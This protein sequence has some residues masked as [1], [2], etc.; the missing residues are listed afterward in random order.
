QW[1]TEAN[2]R[3]DVGFAED[4]RR[5]V[6]RESRLIRIGL[7]A[8][9][10]VTIGFGG[11]FIA[12]A[13]TLASPADVMLAAEVWFFILVTWAGCLWIARGTWRPL[14]ETTAAFID[15][16]IR[17]CRSNLR[18]ASF[19]AWLYVCQLLFVVLWKFYSSSIELTVL[20]TAW[21]V[22]LLGWLGL[23]AFFAL[24]FWFVRRQR[25]ELDRLLELEH[26]LTARPVDDA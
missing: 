1:R 10:L 19:G 26:E 25:A 8:P 24:R 15:I 11:G 2:A 5:R 12:R 14:A 23:P 20:L 4:F 16:S 22:I 9:I 21:P 3:N 13:L 7:I 6:T 17:R 18:G